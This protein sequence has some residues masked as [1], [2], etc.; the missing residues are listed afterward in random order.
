MFFKKKINNDI[1][2]S[3]TFLGLPEIVSASTISRL[4]N[5]AADGLRR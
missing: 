5:S 4:I 2:F 1:V 3:S